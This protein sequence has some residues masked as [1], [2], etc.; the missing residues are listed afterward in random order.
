M[1]LVCL[2][3]AIFILGE[4]LAIYLFF[5]S[6]NDLRTHLKKNKR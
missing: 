4:P 6:I 1:L 2:G 3:I 5:K